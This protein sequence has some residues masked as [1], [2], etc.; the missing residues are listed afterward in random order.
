MDEFGV[1]FENYFG[2][3]RMR[4]IP[5]FV[6]I[7]ILLGGCNSQSVSFRNYEIT[8]LVPPSTQ[9]RTIPNLFWNPFSPQ[10]WPVI[11]LV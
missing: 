4:K 8:Q 3:G 9:N 5:F 1:K 10:L 11:Q 6:L 7:I 2:N